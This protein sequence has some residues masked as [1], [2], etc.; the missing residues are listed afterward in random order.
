[1]SFFLQI[2]VRA[3]R[4]T[5]CFVHHSGRHED[6]DGVELPS[7]AAL[8]STLVSH[9]RDAGGRSVSRRAARAV[10]RGVTEHG[11]GIR[12]G[13]SGTRGVRGETREFIFIYVWAIRMTACFVTGG[14]RLVRDWCGE[15]PNR[16]FTRQRRAVGRGGG[17]VRIRGGVR[18][19]K[20]GQAK[21]PGRNRGGRR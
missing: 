7:R 21:D 18:F 9:R 5:S 10:T 6:G 2:S 4:L 1:M 16:G 14:R 3:I 15:P 20:D 8:V 19:G 13:T 17:S 11:G 12:P